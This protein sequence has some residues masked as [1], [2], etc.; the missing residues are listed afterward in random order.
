MDF[1]VVKHIVWSFV[2]RAWWKTWIRFFSLHAK[3]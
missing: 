3:S 1:W 2:T